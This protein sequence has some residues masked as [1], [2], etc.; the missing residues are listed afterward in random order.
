MPRLT[1]DNRPV[2]V[3]KGTKVIA[4]AEQLGIYIPR[5]CYHEALGSVGACRMCAVMFLEGPV[6]GLEMSCMTEARDG[7]VV[8]TVHPEAQAFR[9]HVVEW[10]MLNHPHD[11]PVCDEGG[12]CLLQDMTVSSGHG[13]R[14]YDGPKRTYRDQDLGPFV[15][16]EMNRCI[17]CWRCRR[18]YQEYAGGRD[19]GAMQIGWRTYFGRQQS[20]RLQ[21]PFAGNVVDLCPTGVYTDKPS[22]YEGRYWDFARAESICPHCSL[23]CATTLNVRYRR[24]VRQEARPSLEVNGHFIC[25]RGRYGYGFADH[26]R[27]PRT[28]RIDGQEVE[29]NAALRKA[30]K[31]LGF[32]AREHGPSAVAALGSPRLGLEG[33]IALQRLCAEQGWSGARFFLEPDLALRVRAVAQG[34]TPQLAV[35]LRELER[36]DFILAVGVEP[37]GEA[38]MLAL[39]LR[40]A[41]RS[42]ATVGRLD[43]RPSELPLTVKHLPLAPGVL[44]NALAWLVKQSFRA[45]ERRK[46]EAE[47]PHLMGPDDA[48]GLSKPELR[49]L[50]RLARALAKSE[51]PVLVCGTDLVPQG[52]PGRAAGLAGVLG[53]H[54]QEAGLFYVLPGANAMGAALVNPDE[55]AE[56]NLLEAVEA[57]E[58]KALLAVE[59]DPLFSFPDRARLARALEGLELLVVLDHLPNPCEAKAGVFLPVANLFEG[60]GASLVNQEGRLQRALSAGE[61]G[62]P[63]DQV[64]GGGHPPRV[65]SLDAPGGGLLSSAALLEQMARELSTH[66]EKLPRQSGWEWLAERHPGFAHLF[67]HG[68]PPYGQRLLPLSLGPH[69]AE[70]EPLAAMPGEDA[71]EIL[72]S[73]GFMP[74]EELASYSPVLAKVAEEAVLYLH[75]ATAEG[76]GLAAPGRV[77]LRLEQGEL[78]LP[79]RLAEGLHPRMAWLVP[80]PGHAWQMLRGRRQVLPVANLRVGGGS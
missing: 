66:S 10:L 32:I 1:I 56:D 39:A 8:S 72:V 71:L 24:V 44:E 40:K 34:L 29:T 16:H 14:R 37:L 5:F 28:A 64:S 69:E 17:H 23:G 77:R 76:L 57:G 67:E 50:K 35:S 74:G 41:W 36:A 59:S 38:P 60:Q 61:V 62:T 2:E 22:R 31:R 4:A 43:P 20:G 51:R 9:R 80:G 45:K 6:K 65:Y 7:M 25:D 78:E 27:R 26:H 55:G 19:L 21:S 11:C 58:V 33:M 68:R 75:P 18:F 3:A 52:L 79:L 48:A 15:S 70:D 53:E 49:E 30:A 73:P 42:G 13:I 12:Q 54:G 46:L 47:H 63:L